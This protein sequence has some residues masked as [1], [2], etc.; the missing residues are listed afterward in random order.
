MR[1]FFLLT[2]TIVLLT[3]IV[4]AAKVESID[5]TASMYRFTV[6]DR[7]Y[8]RESASF[9]TNGNGKWLAIDSH[10][11][12]GVGI[13]KSIKYVELSLIEDREPPFPPDTKSVTLYEIAC[14]NNENRN[15][16]VDDIAP[17]ISYGDEI[18]IFDAYE[19]EFHVDLTTSSVRKAVLNNGLEI[20]EALK[21]EHEKHGYG[22]YFKVEIEYFTWELIAHAYAAE[23]GFPGYWDS[24][25]ADCNVLNTDF[26]TKA[27]IEVARML[28]KKGPE[29][30]W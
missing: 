17:T 14:D 19:G 21:Q 9:Y 3:G 1:K 13:I 6:G 5:I 23:F 16:W 24:S 28:W 4:I 7:V 26:V 27:M 25:I 29:K 22:D 2:I 18:I 10:P 8:I 20:A 12:E 15:S 30:T 11:S